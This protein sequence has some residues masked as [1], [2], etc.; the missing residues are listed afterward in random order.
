MRRSKL[1]TQTSVALKCNIFLFDEGV[2]EL[3]LLAAASDELLANASQISRVPN[4]GRDEDAGERHS[5]IRLQF[6]RLQKVPIPFGTRRSVM[7]SQV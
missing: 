3:G 7:P 1:N 5:S 6:A 4:N 2:E